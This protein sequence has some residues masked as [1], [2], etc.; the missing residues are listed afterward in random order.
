MRITKFGH[1]C[2]RLSHDGSDVVIDPGGWSETEALDGVAAVLVTHEHA[3]HWTID[4]LRATDAQW[5]KVYWGRKWGSLSL[6]LR[7]PS[8]AQNSPRSVDDS[9]S[10][11]FTR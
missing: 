10:L 3:D 7:P 4:Q 9:N 5:Q 1:S 8:G 6:I 11:F 2:V